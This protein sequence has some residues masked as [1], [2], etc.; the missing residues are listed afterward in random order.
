MFHSL[1]QLSDDD[2][3]MSVGSR[4]SVRVSITPT[5]TPFIPLTIQIGFPY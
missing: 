2:E 4:G 1:T 5:E 3:R